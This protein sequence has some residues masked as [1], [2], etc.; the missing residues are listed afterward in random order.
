MDAQLKVIRYIR[1]YI[2]T[3]KM[4]GKKKKNL[5]SLRNNSSIGLLQ[6]VRNSAK[7]KKGK[8]NRTTC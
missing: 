6:G 7:R 5:T 3:K 2:Y 8:N 1:L 4:K